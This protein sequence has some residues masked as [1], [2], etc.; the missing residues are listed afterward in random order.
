MRFVQVEPMLD[1]IL[2]AILSGVGGMLTDRVSGVCV[3]WLADE[4]TAFDFPR[5]MS[6]SPTKVE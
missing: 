4:R 5:I 2:A 1:I 3:V 6:N